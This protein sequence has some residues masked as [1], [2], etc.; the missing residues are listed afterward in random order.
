MKVLK[1]DQYTFFT[2]AYFIISRLISNQSCMFNW[3]S[4]S[5]FVLDLVYGNVGE[6]CVNNR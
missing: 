6:N 1:I 3:I 2:T 4:N 5:K